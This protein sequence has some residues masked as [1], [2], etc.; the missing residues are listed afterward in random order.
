[1]N[2]QSSTAN[3]WT[4]VVIT[5]V[6]VP[7]TNEF[8][9]GK[10]LLTQFF[11]I[12]PGPLPAGGA[13][14]CNR[15]TLFQLRGQTP[16]NQGRTET[17]ELVLLGCRLIMRCWLD[18]FGNS[19]MQKLVWI[20]GCHHASIVNLLNVSCVLV[21]PHQ[22][23]LLLA[24]ER[25]HFATTSVQ[26]AELSLRRENLS[27]FFEDAYFKNRF[28]KDPNFLTFEIFKIIYFPIAVFRPLPVLLRPRDRF[29]R[30]RRKKLSRS[31]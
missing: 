21:V 8:P 28:S 15:T 1:M 12:Q 18:F 30:D 19:S 17:R 2:F 11:H 23:S 24:N 25:T 22:T 16:P 3:R 31:S 13:P 6:T 4:K 9:K 26:T 27:R 5:L 20:P 7:D 14:V 10:N 29:F